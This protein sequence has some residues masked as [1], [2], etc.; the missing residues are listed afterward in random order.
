VQD[1]NSEPHDASFRL[2]AASRLVENS[3]S[4]DGGQGRAFSARREA[5]LPLDGH[6]SGGYTRRKPRRDAAFPPR[7]FAFNTFTPQ[8]PRVTEPVTANTPFDIEP[9]DS[10]RVD[11]CKHGNACVYAVAHCMALIPFAFPQ[12]YRPVTLQQPAGGDV[13][14]LY[15]LL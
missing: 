5:G 10:I 13:S 6:R 9:A 14:L 1:S 8:Q 12:S 4:E 7:S 3:R 2:A 11:A 15:P